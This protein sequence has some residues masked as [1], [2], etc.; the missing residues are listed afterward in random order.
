MELQTGVLSTLAECFLGDV[1][2]TSEWRHHCYGN[3][4]MTSIGIEAWQTM[5]SLLRQIFNE[6]EILSTE[7]SDFLK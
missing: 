4:S 2:L 6:T 3:I 1:T 5:H 7:T